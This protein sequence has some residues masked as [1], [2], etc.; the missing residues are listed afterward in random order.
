[1]IFK[2]MKIGEFPGL[3]IYDY[4]KN[5]DLLA[6]L[7]YKEKENMLIANTIEKDFVSFLRTKGFEHYKNSFSYIKSIEHVDDVDILFDEIAKNVLLWKYA[8]K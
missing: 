7:I 2:K 8:E 4:A 6:S 1:M 5:G 3:K